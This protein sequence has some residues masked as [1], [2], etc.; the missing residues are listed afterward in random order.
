[1]CFSFTFKFRIF[2]QTHNVSKFLSKLGMWNIIFHHF[3]KKY[4][5]SAIID[6]YYH[7]ELFNLPL[8]HFIFSLNF[9]GIIWNNFEGVR[10][11]NF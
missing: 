1:M 3:T 7:T 6:L 10:V 5:K 11:T 8:N 2:T 9:T 4:P